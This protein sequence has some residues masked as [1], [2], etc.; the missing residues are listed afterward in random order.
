MKLEVSEFL[1]LYYCREYYFREFSSNKLPIESIFFCTRD[2]CDQTDQ[3]LLREK[4][5]LYTYTWQPMFCPSLLTRTSWTVVQDVACSYHRTI[6]VTLNFDQ[7]PMTHSIDGQ[8]ARHINWKFVDAGLKRR[9][10]QRLDSTLDAAGGGLLLVNRGTDANRLKTN[11]ILKSSKEIFGMRK[12]SKLN[13]SGWI[14][15]E[16]S[17]MIDTCREAVSH[18]NITGR[19]ISKARAAFRHEMKFFEREWE[20]TSFSINA[21]KLQRSECNDFWKEIKAIIPKEG[22]SA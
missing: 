4:F 6:T 1:V 20:S 8:K 13:V 16:R 21:V 2:N 12:P 3:H 5:S 18:W 10:Y 7:L 17:W 19:S 22:V 15:R 14:E 11:A 9:F